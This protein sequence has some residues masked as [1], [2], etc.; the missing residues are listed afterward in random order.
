MWNMI[1]LLF[2][3]P[4]AQE[5]YASPNLISVS[6]DRTVVEYDLVTATNDAI[7]IKVLFFFFF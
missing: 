5:P 3:P 1:A 4:N 7:K 2:E 6:E